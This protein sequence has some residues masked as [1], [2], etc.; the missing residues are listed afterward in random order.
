MHADGR[1]GRVPTLREEH[2]IDEHVDFAALV[3]GQCLR[4]LDGRGAAADGLRFQPCCAEFAREVVGVFH[5]GRVDDA[6]RLVEPVAVEARRGLVDHAVVQD[7]GQDLLVVV[8][9]DD[10]DRGN[11]RRRWHAEAP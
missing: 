1:A 8:A 6:R 5:A 7:A 9:A 10:R 2:C 11:R 3:R 4:E